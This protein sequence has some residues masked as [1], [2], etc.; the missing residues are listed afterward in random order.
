M[1][2][3]DSHG[4]WGGQISIAPSTARKFHYT[5]SLA[6]NRTKI[7]WLEESYAHHYTTNP[8]PPKYYSAR[9]KH[10]IVYNAVQ[11]KGVVTMEGGAL[12]CL[13]RVELSSWVEPKKD[14]IPPFTHSMCLSFPLWYIVFWKWGAF[15]AVR[16][17]RSMLLA[18][19]GGT[20]LSWKTQL[21]DWFY[22]EQCNST[23][24]FWEAVHYAQLNR[25]STLWSWHSECSM[26]SMQFVG[27]GRRGAAPGILRAVQF[28]HCKDSILT[29]IC[30]KPSIN[31]I[32]KF[33]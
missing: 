28:S 15:A 31:Q 5:Q 6:G 14:T 12:G 29:A 30:M 27:W 22:S 4:F 10:I 26:D 17:L 32:T 7:S 19:A 33:M 18:I 9:I 13:R 3:L 21:Y 8:V 1:E 25:Q 23:C 2:R 20:D 11:G 24:S 16:I